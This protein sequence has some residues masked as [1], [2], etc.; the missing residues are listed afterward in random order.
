[1]DKFYYGQIKILTWRYNAHLDR[2][3]MF[4]HSAQASYVYIFSLINGPKRN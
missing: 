1:M 2:D 4:V 3:V